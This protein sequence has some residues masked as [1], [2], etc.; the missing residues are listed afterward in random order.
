MEPLQKD[1]L[2]FF[3]SYIGSFYEEPD[4][5]D[6]LIRRMMKVKNVQ[7]I[8]IDC[9]CRL[10]P[11]VTKEISKT[12]IAESASLKTV[13]INESRLLKISKD[14]KHLMNNYEN[15]QSK[16]GSV[17]SIINSLDTSLLSTT[18]IEKTNQEK[19]T[20]SYLVTFLS[21]IPKKQITT[22]EEIDD[23][24]S[25]TWS[26]HNEVEKLLKKEI[27]TYSIRCNAFEN[28]YYYKVR[29]IKQKAGNKIKSL[30]KEIE[31][32]TAYYIN[33]INQLGMVNEDIKSQQLENFN[34]EQEILN[35]KIDFTSAPDLVTAGGIIK[36]LAATRLVLEKNR[37][38]DDKIIKGLN[39]KLSMVGNKYT[40]SQE[41]CSKLMRNLSSLAWCF[42]NLIENSRLGPEEKIE[43]LRL[44]SDQEYLQIEEK[45]RDESFMESYSQENISKKFDSFRE[46][47]SVISQ[48]IK[49]ENV[50]AQL[51]KVTEDF[52]ID[53][54]K[55]KPKLNKNILIED[56][57]DKSPRKYSEKQKTSPISRSNKSPIHITT[58]KTRESDKSSFVESSLEAIKKN[59]LTIEEEIKAKNKA[60]AD[61]L[62]FFTKSLRTPVKSRNSLENEAISIS[63]FRSYKNRKEFISKE[64]QTDEEFL[65]KS[66][67][68]LS[69]QT[70][71]KSQDTIFTQTDVIKQKVLIVNEE[72]RY[73]YTEKE[74]LEEVFYEKKDQ[75]TQTEKPQK[76]FEYTEIKE[77]KELN[78]SSVLARGLMKKSTILPKTENTTTKKHE[79]GAMIENLITERVSGLALPIKEL[80]K[81]NAKSERYENTYEEGKD[82]ADEYHKE[83]NI[84]SQFFGFK[85][86]SFIEIQR[87]WE[88]VINRRLTDGEKDKIS[89]YLRGY[90][91]TDQFDL[92]KNKIIGL[93]EAA[94]ND[95][96]ANNPFMHLIKEFKNKIYILD[97]WK[98]VLLKVFF[99][100]SK[101]NANKTN[102]YS[103]VVFKSAV[104]L[105]FIKNNP[106][107][108]DGKESMKKSE[109][110]LIF[111]PDKWIVSSPSPTLISKRVVTSRFLRKNKAKTEIK[112]ISR[113][114]TR[115]STK[116]EL[117]RFPLIQHIP[118]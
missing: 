77:P 42:G 86:T 36:S 68:E 76:R 99:M 113:T 57:I 81:N 93:L 117:T 33:K 23:I 73:A 106:I 56:R 64:I 11:I 65:S 46:S 104:F 20:Q 14:A 109:T 17:K 19:T 29:A 54:Q 59:F 97:N 103:D 26:K 22:G 49:N 10:E 118:K 61:D 114:P 69:Q 90:L 110:S 78:N 3:V 37:R 111:K 34:L 62:I 41:H 40:E 100:V 95:T 47:L 94:K 35:Q 43:I 98:R 51:N 75:Q 84:Q 89:V 39:L 9:M 92:E 63:K 115:M 45:L 55:I 24:S 53:I 101:E 7:R 66:W 116:N 31:N 107:S 18:D 12:K 108:P 80:T 60:L 88:E 32:V 38:I 79:I 44:L 5:P 72:G 13:K 15:I 102:D 83:F 25:D 87:L 28:K 21:S 82:A 67:V 2:K 52:H 85:K 48:T 96:S 105:R 58:P 8:I 50:K 30:E 112:R 16:L 91:G 70:D 4:L 6:K 74:Q 27:E 71:K 1:L